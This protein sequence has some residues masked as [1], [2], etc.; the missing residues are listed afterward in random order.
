MAIKHEQ[1]K[2]PYYCRRTYKLTANPHL[3]K[4]VEMIYLLSGNCIAIADN[5]RLP[6]QPGDLFVCFPNQVHYYLT[7]EQPLDVFVILFSTNM[8]FGMDK[9]FLTMSPK[10]NL[11]HL[12]SGSPLDELIRSLPPTYSNIP[13]THTAG[14]LN[15]LMSEITPRLHLTEHTQSPSTTLQSILNYCEKHF[16]EQLTLD[17][18]AEELHLSKYYI[19]RLLNERVQLGFSDY[20]NFLRVNEACTLLEI[21][22]DRR[23]ADV[24]GEVGFGSI[25][26]FNRAFQKIMQITPI[27]YRKRISSIRS[28]GS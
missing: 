27:T 9:E 23:I 3:H 20:I 21:N 6:M 16:R 10:N 1:K 14:H 18:A 12:D 17:L 19:S 15:L 4:E 22:P 8:I 13:L 5:L 25:R 24:S 11:I 26:S 28:S 7:L 2:T